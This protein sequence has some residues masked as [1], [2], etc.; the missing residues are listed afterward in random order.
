MK[1]CFISHTDRLGGA[2][3]VL[4]ESI[5]ILQARGIHCYVLL[6]KEGELSSRLTAIGVHYDIAHNSSWVTW[7]TPTLWTRITTLANIVIGVLSTIKRIK[8]SRCDIVYSNTLTICNG[9]IA[10]ALLGIPHVWHLHD[11]P[12]YHG[13]RFFFGRGFSLRTIGFLSDTCITVSRHLSDMCRPYIDSAKLKTV[14]PSMQMVD[15]STTQDSFNGATDKSGLLRCVI[16]GGLV[17]TKR[18]EDAVRALGHLSK[19]G[20]DAELFIVGGGDP[21]YQQYL[22]QVAASNKVAHRLYFSGPVSDAFSLIQTADVVLMCSGHET[23]GRATIEGMLAGKPVIAA[24][25]AATSELVQDGVT[26]LLYEFGDY[27]DLAD[28]IKKLCEDSTLAK[29]V[30]KSAQSWSRSF[31]TQERYAGEMLLLLTSCRKQQHQYA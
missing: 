3:R 29:R 16:V 21:E 17:P 19:I 15:L 12:G 22:E 7:G 5:T 20:I 30:G 26:G 1:V 6:P 10:A 4:L 25:A 31:F 28:K 14:Y 9:A 24:R 11:F 8:R 18:Q 27:L 2:E 23:F 13:I